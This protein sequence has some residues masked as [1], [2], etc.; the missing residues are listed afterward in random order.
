MRASRWSGSASSVGIGTI[1]IEIRLPYAP[2]SSSVRT[3]TGTMATSGSSGSASRSSSH[4]RTAPAHS[5]TTTSLTVMPTAFLSCLTV[6]R[7]SWPNAKRRCGEIAPLNGVRGGRAVVDSSTLA[8]C[9]VT[10]L[11]SRPTARESVGPPGITVAP[12][13]SVTFGSVVGTERSARS[14]WRAT[15]SSPRPSISTSPGTRSRRAPRPAAGSPAPPGP[16]RAAR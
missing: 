13:S 5:A 3:D 7:E 2:F 12:G 16:G 14:G 9:R 8:S 10:A 1:I 15:P 6:S 11:R 4:S